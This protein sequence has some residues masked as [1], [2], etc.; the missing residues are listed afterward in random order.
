MNSRTYIDDNGDEIKITKDG[1]VFVNGNCVQEPGTDA[2]FDS[3]TVKVQNEEGYYNSDGRYV[4][5][6][7]E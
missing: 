6:E 3:H 2:D 4:S 1:Y 5:Y 7:K